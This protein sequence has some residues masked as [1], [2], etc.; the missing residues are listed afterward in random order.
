MGDSA[1]QQGLVDAYVANSQQSKAV[2]YLTDL[3][4]KILTQ[5]GADELAAAPVAAPAL[6][7]AGS[8]DATAD[9]AAAE[10]AVAATAAALPGSD[11]NTSADATTVSSSSSEAVES[12]VA[13]T[14]DRV[15]VDPIA[16]QL[17]LGKEVM[18]AA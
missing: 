12:A 14:S 6:E 4:D 8:S 15:A 16:V 5:A 13:S 17:L 10:S 18:L 1:A 2:K 11:D 3:R 9:T 7:A